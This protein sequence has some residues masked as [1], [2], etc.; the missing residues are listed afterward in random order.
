MG[1]YLELGEEAR[2]NR[3]T[4]VI[5]D[6]NRFNRDTELTKAEMEIFETLLDREWHS[7]A[8]LGKKDGRSEINVR[9]LISKLRKKIKKYIDI[10]SKHGK[11]EY[12]CV[13]TKKKKERR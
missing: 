3:S 9:V 10:E 7:I 11:G 6:E 2:Y 4:G 13:R 12:R 5:T 8:E 1:I